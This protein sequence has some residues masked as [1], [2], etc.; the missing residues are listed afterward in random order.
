MITAAANVTV[1]TFRNSYESKGEKY[2]DIGPGIAMQCMQVS[3]TQ[4]NGLTPDGQ[5]F[6]LAVF[7]AEHDYVCSVSI[8]YENESDDDPSLFATHRHQEFVDAVTKALDLPDD[9]V[10]FFVMT[11]RGPDFALLST[12]A[13]AAGTFHDSVTASVFGR[14]LGSSLSVDDLPCSLV[15]EVAR[16]FWGRAW[17]PQRC[18]HNKMPPGGI[19][20][21]HVEDDDDDSPLGG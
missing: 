4:A 19:P 7:G 8:E 5:S 15:Y 9:P 6:N 11:W 10:K 3:I 20:V 21:I 18:H 14:V 16:H 17:E 1:D 13:E 2:E 12:V